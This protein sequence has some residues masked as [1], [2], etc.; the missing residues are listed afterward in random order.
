MVPKFAISLLL[1]AFGLCGCASRPD[2]TVD[3]LTGFAFPPI[4]Q[5]A[6][7]LAETARTMQIVIIRQPQPTLNSSNMSGDVWQPGVA[8]VATSMDPFVRDATLNHE[9]C[10]EIMFRLT[11]NYQWHPIYAAGG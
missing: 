2:V 9:A 6:Q 4:C 8:Q 11:G 7:L 5:N 3:P 1:A 10:H